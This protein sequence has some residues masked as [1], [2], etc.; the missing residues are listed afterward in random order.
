MSEETK[1]KIRKK[2][3]QRFFILEER[4]FIKSKMH[5]MDLKSKKEG[6]FFNFH[7][8]VKKNFC[9]MLTRKHSNM[10]LRNTFVFEGDDEKKI[11]HDLEI[12]LE[13]FFMK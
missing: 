4:F 5:F 8:L 6:E 13:K 12:L 3:E 9:V 11:I 1:L 10:C 7:Y 2:L